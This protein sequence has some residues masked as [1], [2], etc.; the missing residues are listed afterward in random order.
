MLAYISQPYSSAMAMRP[1]VTYTP[2]ATSSKGK[3]VNIITFAQFEEGDLLSEN[4]EDAE[5][6]DESGDRYD[7]DSIVPQLI[8]KEKRIRWNLAM[9]Q[10]MIIYLRK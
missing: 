9:S 7:D 3:F 6:N 8:S 4:P 2:C 5:S 10:I 1:Y